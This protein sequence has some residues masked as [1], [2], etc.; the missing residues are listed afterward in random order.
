V[1][2]PFVTR[3]NTGEGSDFFLRG[4]ATRSG[5]WNLLGAQD[6]LPMEVCGEGGALRAGI[7]YDDAYDG[8]SSLRV[9]GTATADARRLYLFEAGAPLPRRQAFTL[10][11]RRAGG[12]GAPAPHVVV[13][14]GGQGPIDL[15]PATRTRDEGWTF[16]R[17]R[18][19]PSVAPGTLTRIGVGF[20]V[21]ADRRVDALIGELG[22]VDLASYERPAQIGPR[23]TSGGTL[24][25]HDPSASTTRHYNVWAVV[26]R[27]SC[28]ELVGRSASPRYDLG[29]PLFAIPKDARR[30]VVQPVSTS[31]LASRLSPPPCEPIRAKSRDAVTHSRGGRAG[32]ATRVSK[33]RSSAS[34]PR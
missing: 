27:K 12:A 17:A 30:F 3:F 22:V 5:D 1:R 19:P 9:S 33:R 8:G 34:R 16:T 6:A 23:P 13:W 7:D 31:G 28:V 32:H 15:E 2:V 11:F 26:P 20:D 18:L 4:R 24:R 14:V 21:T 25:W 29:Q 10:R